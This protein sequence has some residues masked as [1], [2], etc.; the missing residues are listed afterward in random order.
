M[1]PPS[2]AQEQRSY[3]RF[4][5]TAPVT[6]HLPAGGLST[7]TTRNVSIA[8]IGLKSIPSWQADIGENLTLEFDVKEFGIQLFIEAIIAWRDPD[9]QLIGLTFRMG[10]D[11]LSKKI[12]ALI[13]LL[14]KL[15]PPTTP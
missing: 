9:N 13:N 5:I 14:N 11:S 6:I 1:L 10:R 3:P 4:D 15:I 12:Q 8:G 2:P 7:T